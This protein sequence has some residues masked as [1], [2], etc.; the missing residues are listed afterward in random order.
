MAPFWELFGS[1]WASFSEP[2]ENVQMWTPPR[3]E[4]DIEGPGDS[5]NHT[6]SLTFSRSFG[7]RVSGSLLR[8]ILTTWAPFGGPGATRERPES[9]PGAFRDCTGSAP[10]AT[11]RTS[12]TLRERFGVLSERSRSSLERSGRSG[13][14]GRPLRAPRAHRE[15]RAPIA[16]PARALR[17]PRAPTAS[18]ARLVFPCCW[19]L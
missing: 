7:G 15:P 6:F 19:V 13:V 2:A 14:R 18:P 17:A 9:A 11:R 4:L 3:R 5:P 16:C 12:G 10:R 8:G 1:L